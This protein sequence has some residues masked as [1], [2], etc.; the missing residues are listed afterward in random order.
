MLRET[1]YGRVA[2]MLSLWR[3]E[4]WLPV[5]A[6]K[7]LSLKQE[8]HLK[9]QRVIKAPIV[10]F[11]KLHKPGFMEIKTLAS[12]SKG[13]CYIIGRELMIECGIPL[14][15]IKRKGGFKVHEIQ[16]CLVSHEH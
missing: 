5:T 11:Y 3:R 13:N 16:A 15:E 4:R 9:L 2:R 6:V 14:K 7:L 12:S 1:Y 10:A 8:M